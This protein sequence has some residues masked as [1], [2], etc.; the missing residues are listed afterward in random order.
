MSCE[1]CQKSNENDYVSYFSEIKVG[2]NIYENINDIFL[3]VSFSKRLIYMYLVQKLLYLQKFYIS[4]PYLLDSYQNCP[5]SQHYCR[6][7]NNLQCYHRDLKF[8]NSQ[9]YLSIRES[10]SVRVICTICFIYNINLS[11]VFFHI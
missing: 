5:S 6:Y 11:S 1:K 7:L 9:I 4:S 8:L 3:I 2:V 10:F